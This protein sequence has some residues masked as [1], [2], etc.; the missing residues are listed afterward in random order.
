MC[1]VVTAAVVVGA[2]AIYAGEKAEDAAYAASQKATAAMEGSEATSR[3]LNEQRFGEAQDLLNPYISASEAART[4][5]EQQ[6][7]LG[8]VAGNQTRYMDEFQYVPGRDDIG[9]RQEQ[10]AGMDSISP[11]NPATGQVWRKADATTS[12]QEENIKNRIMS[13]QNEFALHQHRPGADR[14][15]SNEAFWSSPAIQERLVVDQNSKKLFYGADQSFFTGDPSSTGGQ[16]YEGQFSVVPPGDGGAYLQPADRMDTNVVPGIQSDVQQLSP[17]GGAYMS[18]LE[19]MDTNVIPGV[20]SDIAQ[21]APGG[22]AYL[23]QPT[24]EQ[25]G[26]YFS[27]LAPEGGM[28]RDQQEMIDPTQYFSDL[29]SGY[30]AFTANPI[31]QQM[32][33]AGAETAL[34]SAAAGGMARSGSTLEALRDVGQGVSTDWFNTYMGTMGD[35]TGINE[36]RRR[37]DMAV[38]EQRYAN[39]LNIG[40]GRYSDV[41]NINE[42]RFANAQN[43]TEGRRNTAIGINEQRGIE[44]RGINEQRYANLQ[45]ITE[46]RRREAVGYNEQRD[47][48]TQNIN[49]QRYA[50]Y[51]NLSEQRGINER[52]TE[53]QR[54]VNY[55]NMLQ[56]LSSPGTATNLASLGVNQGIAQGGQSTQAVANT[57]QYN[58]GAT[59]ASNA[60]RADMVGGLTNLASAYIGSQGNQPTPY[61]SGGYGYGGYTG[62]TIYGGANAPR[63][64]S[65]AGYA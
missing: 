1:G 55:M 9:G 43:I 23:D 3:T 61:A 46:A 56:N 25:L 44:E 7:G 18:P 64:T 19:R 24:G 2:G 17:T 51:M 28:Y 48:N 31:Y 20:Q 14:Y 5:L 13:M 11:I 29:T 34:G 38:E 49:E 15:E 60:A 37:A 10:F 63:P 62:G 33:D 47:I 6:L 35:L 8:R 53:E 54:Y 39:Y 59:A 27:S 65:Y 57:T 42:Q 32:I 30:E 40:E 36:E 26:D 41:Q 45:N 58:L 16:T 50:N 22:S 21:L 52:N 12:P 4:A